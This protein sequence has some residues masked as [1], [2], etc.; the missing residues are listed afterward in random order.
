MDNLTEQNRQ[1]FIEL[2][3]STNRDGVEYIIEDLD[4]WGYFTAPASSNQHLN[5]EG[6]LAQHS[7]NVYEMAIMLREQIIARRPDLAQRLPMDSIII[8]SLLHDVCKSR[9]YRK[10]IRR[11]RNAISV[12]DTYEA[13]EVDYSDLPIGHGEKS[14][15]M[16]LRSGM[17]LEDDEVTAIRWH[18]SAWDLAFQSYE[19]TKSLNVARDK[20]PLSS[21]IH[22]AD[23]LAA[24]LIERNAETIN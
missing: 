23:T 15:I 2:L 22:S 8:A 14:V 7:L 13:Y 9:I 1:K 4:S 19:M 10:V 24:N 20:C 16:I 5:Y 21:L 17:Y 12:N 11:N 3:K 6:G 18:M